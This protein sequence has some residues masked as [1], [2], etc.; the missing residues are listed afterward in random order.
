MDFFKWTKDLKRHLPKKKERQLVDRHKTFSI[1]DDLADTSQSTRQHFPTT[2]M[3]IL[4]ISKIKKN[5][6]G[7][8]Y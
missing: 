7:Q 5:K 3:T 2:R 8:E 6:C 4:L 1:I